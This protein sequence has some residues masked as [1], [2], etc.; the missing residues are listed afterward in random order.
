MNFH[1]SKVYGVGVSESEIPG[2]ARV[3]G[4]EAASFPFKYLGVPIGSN[5]DLKRNWMPVIERFHS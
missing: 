1:K 2:Y 4:C 3:L 5:M